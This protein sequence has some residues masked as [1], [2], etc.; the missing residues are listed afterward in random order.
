LADPRSNWLVR[1]LLDGTFG[2]LDGE[3]GGPLGLSGRGNY[4]SLASSGDL[5][6]VNMA[7]YHTS[8]LTRAIAATGMSYGTFDWM[9]NLPGENFNRTHIQHAGEDA[10]RHG[11]GANNRQAVRDFGI[12]SRDDG[13]RREERNGLMT[14]YRA[15]LRDDADIRRLRRERERATTD[16]ERR[17]IDALIQERD[18]VIRREL[19]IGEHINASPT[20]AARE[21]N[22]RRFDEILNNTVGRRAQVLPEMGHRTAQ[23]TSGRDTVP[24]AVRRVVRTEASAPTDRQLVA[25]ADA[26]FGAGPPTSERRVTGTPPPR[27]DPTPT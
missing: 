13:A 23:I 1:A 14:R 2:R 27:Q 25:E 3:R 15:R 26:L 9:R 19:G 22:Q 20:A 5:S 12:L 7:N 11:F 10:R 17:R 16:D 21:A 6:G 4:T 24:D 18:T 8:P